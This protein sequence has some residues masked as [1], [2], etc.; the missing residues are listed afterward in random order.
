VAKVAAGKV[1]SEEIARKLEKELDEMDIDVIGCIHLDT[2]VFK[3][4]V[5]GGV[6]S[7][8]RAAEEIKDV[9]DYILSRASRQPSG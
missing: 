7:K 1:P 9:L 2:E 4:S 8:G 3:S 6:V 5:E